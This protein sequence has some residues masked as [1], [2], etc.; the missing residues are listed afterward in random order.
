[1]PDISM[2]TNTSCPLADKCYRVQAE[3]SFWQAYTPFE[4]RV[5]EDGVEY[6][7]FMEVWPKKEERSQEGSEDD[8]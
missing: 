8:Q 1:M 6:D 4:Y 7:E 2:C 5:A 3:P